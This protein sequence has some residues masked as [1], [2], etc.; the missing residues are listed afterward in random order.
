MIV[1]KYGQCISKNSQ[2][3]CFCG[4]G[5]CYNCSVICVFKRC[6]DTVVE[7]NTS[8]QMNN[9]HDCTLPCGRPTFRFYSSDFSTSIFVITFCSCRK[10]L[11]I[12][13]KVPDNPALINLY[14]N[15][16]NHI[17]SNPFSRSMKS[18]IFFNFLS[19]IDLT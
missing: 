5:C 13:K 14:N 8:E 9:S 12:P 15:S 10:F 11:M 1:T 18:T 3:R 16:S 2:I 19:S 4:L 6:T 17:E 7:L